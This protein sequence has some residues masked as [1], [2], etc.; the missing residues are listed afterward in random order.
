[1]FSA[2]MMPA[3]LAQGLLAPGSEAGLDATAYDIAALPEAQIRNPQ[4]FG[5]RL[6]ANYPS[7]PI[8]HD[9]RGTVT[10]MVRVTTQGRAADCRVLKSSTNGIIDRWACRGTERYARFEPVV[11]ESGKAVEGHWSETFTLT[12]GDPDGAATRPSGSL[13]DR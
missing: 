5:E 7:T 6:I 4:Q 10:I 3:L 13:P 8:R 11:D 1:M 2:M 9:V 12:L